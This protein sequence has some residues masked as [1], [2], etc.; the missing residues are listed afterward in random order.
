MK[1][2]GSRKRRRMKIDKV[3]GEVTDIAENEQ[4]TVLTLSW[5]SAGGYE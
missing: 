4:R 2:K 5:L 3:V 1:R